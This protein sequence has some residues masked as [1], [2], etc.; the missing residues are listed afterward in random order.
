MNA[1]NE[2]AATANFLAYLQVWGLDCALCA[3]RVR[4]R[5]LAVRGVSKS[6]VDRD[7]CLAVALYSPAL[8]SPDELLAAVRTPGD[9]KRHRC[10]AVWLGQV[11][12]DRIRM[13]W[14]S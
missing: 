5:L 6:K 7:E 14:S 8:A 11:P 13:G 10:E 4:T 2:P 1:A 12:A 3:D 9:G